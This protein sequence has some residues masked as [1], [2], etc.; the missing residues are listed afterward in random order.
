MD[1]QALMSALGSL[2]AICQKPEQLQ[3][4]QFLAT[5]PLDSVQAVL[6]EYASKIEPEK[7]PDLVQSE[8]PQFT[9]EQRAVLV[10]QAVDAH[11]FLKTQ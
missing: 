9:P 3:F 8:F 2:A 6:K 11:N 7:L 4:L 1:Q 5:Q 10:Q